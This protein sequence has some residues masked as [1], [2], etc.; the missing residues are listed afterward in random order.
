M[1]IET[2]ESN[3]TLETWINRPYISDNLKTELS[4]AKILFV[5]FENLRDF[6]TP[7]FPLETSDL[8]RYFKNNVPASIDVDI[9]I[10]DDLYTEFAFYNNYKRL[11]NF[12]IVAVAVPIFVGV[13]SSYV[14]EKFLKE[15]ESKPTINVVDRSTH[16]TINAPEISKITT[17]K[18]LQPTQVKFSVT[19]VDSTGKS[20][21]IKF[22]G[23]AKDIDTALKALKDYE[24]PNDSIQVS[25]NTP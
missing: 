21:T 1:K 18:Y 5:P 7:L 20:K 6:E 9:C 24:E 2:L 13:I 12:V 10:T 14:Y 25:A 19:V 11:G 16:V 3:E 22:E 15:E 17:K 23:A 4:T 8:L